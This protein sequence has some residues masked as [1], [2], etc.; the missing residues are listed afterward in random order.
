MP[1]DESSYYFLRLWRF[2]FR[3]FRY[4]C[5]LI[6][7][8]RFLTSEPNAN[9]R[10]T[11]QTCGIAATNRGPGVRRS[12]RFADLGRLRKRYARPMDPA[13]FIPF[14]D[15]ALDGMLGIAATLGDDLVNE[16]PDLPGANSP[17]AIVTH[18]V[19]VTDWWVGVMIAG[20]HVERDRDAEF[21][22][23]GTVADLVVA[24]DGVMARLRS[25]LDGMTPAAP[26]RHPE[27]LPAG[28]PARTWS[29]SAALIHTLEE[30]AQHHGQLE[31]TRDVLTR[32]TE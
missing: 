27:Y 16:R 20:R 6:F 18:S 11:A 5:L 25:D 4:L 31:L 26:I 10:S 14:L 15:T 1:V 7:F 24:V 2:A 9:L 21:T 30:L 23:T 8:R 22:A 12:H 32:S 13:E 29:Q 28:S 3:R 19:G 17:F